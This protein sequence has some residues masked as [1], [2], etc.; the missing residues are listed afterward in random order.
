MSLRDIVTTL[1]EA[2]T[3]LQVA[4]EVKPRP[5]TTCDCFAARVENTSAR[6]PGPHRGYF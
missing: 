3:L 4:K 5:L 6:F 2:P 1:A